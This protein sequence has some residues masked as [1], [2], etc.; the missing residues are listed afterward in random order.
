MAG[1]R[2]RSGV[3]NSLS[4][5]EISEHVL[6]LLHHDLQNILFIERRLYMMQQMISFFASKSRNLLTHGAANSG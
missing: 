2:T 5:Q 4:D 6:L 3:C 1:D